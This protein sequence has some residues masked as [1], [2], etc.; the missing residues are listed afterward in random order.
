M[1]LVTDCENYL[2]ISKWLTCL[3]EDRLLIP[4]DRLILDD[5]V[6]LLYVFYHEFASSRVE[7]GRSSRSTIIVKIEK[8][9]S[10]KEKVQLADL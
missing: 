7:I 2:N 6:C 4:D 3:I 10:K 5:C 8:W 9:Q 1:C